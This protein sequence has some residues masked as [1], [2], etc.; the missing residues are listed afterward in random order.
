[1]L[2]QRRIL[3]LDGLRAIAVG[4]V[5]ISHKVR[6]AGPLNLGGWGVHLFFVLSGFLIIGILFAGRDKI[7]R[8][9]TTFRREIAHFYQ[10]RLFRIWPIYFLT[11]GLCVLAGGVTD[12]APVTQQ[13]FLAVSTFTSNYFQ[14]HVWAKYPENGLG[15]LWSVAVEEQF[16]LWAAPVFLLSPR[17]WFAPICVAVMGIALVAGVVGVLS[18]PT[19]G[20][21]PRSVYVGSMT[22]F[23]LMAMG[24]L[25]AVAIAPRPWMAKAAPVALAAFLAMPIISWLVG[26]E[27]TFSHFAHWLATLLIPVILLGIV[28]DQQAW[29][30]KLLNLPAVAYIGQISYG[31][32]LYHTLI[33]IDLWGLPLPGHGT[34]EAILALAMAAA[35]RR[36]IEK[37]LLDFRDRWRRRLNPAVVNSAPSAAT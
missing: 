10:N 28:A 32:Y 26:V 18:D 29:L 13:Q 33:R 34:I 30:V 31:L 27:T 1:M 3:G 6:I 36:F 21:W 12:A 37:P 8:G 23:G 14:G 22:N 11:I 35:S 19:P 9:T 2:P 16:Y 7:D 20:H 24:G 5:I 25:A 17:K 4:L 15:P